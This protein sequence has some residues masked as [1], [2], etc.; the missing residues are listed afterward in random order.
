MKISNDRKRFEKN[1]R[2]SCD[3][4]GRILK[5]SFSWTRKSWTRVM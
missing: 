3:T 1:L 4:N 2:H 5:A